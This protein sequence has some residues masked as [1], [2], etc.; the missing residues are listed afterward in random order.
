M[1]IGNSSGRPVPASFSNSAHRGFSRKAKS[2]ER[3]S[4]WRHRLWV[5]ANDCKFC[6]SCPELGDTS[7]EPHSGFLSHLVA[8]PATCFQMLFHVYPS[9][10]QNETDFFTRRYQKCL[11]SSPT[12]ACVFPG[13]Q[14]PAPTCSQQVLTRCCSQ[15]G[16]QGGGQ[17]TRT[18]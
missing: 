8:D 15:N 9:V 6:P 10:L 5:S 12:P 3:L 1:P 17:G 14:A 4:G 7:Q 11:P 18:K 16:E 2:R 13:V